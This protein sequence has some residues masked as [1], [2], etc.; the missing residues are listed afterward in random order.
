MPRGPA[1]PAAE[2]TRSGPLNDLS[3][4]EWIRFTRSWFVANP[5][6]RSAAE[7][8]HPAKFPERLADEFLR[9]FTRKGMWVLDPFAGTGSTLV[10]A[11][12]LGRH[13]IGIELVPEFARLAERRAAL[14][15]DDRTR[16]LVLVADSR[17]ITELWRD[18]ALPPVQCVLTSPPYWDVLS[19]GRG[20]VRS[21]HRRRAESGLATVYSGDS[22][23]LANLHDYDAFVTA[24]VGI[25]EQAAAVLEP[26]RYMIVVLQN[27]RDETGRIRRLAWDVAAR[28]EGERLAFQGERIWCQD[29]KPLGIWGYPSTFVPNYH[30]HYCLIF[31]RRAPGPEE[32]PA[33][34]GPSGP[35]TP[36][37]S[38]PPT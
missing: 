10:S 23:D 36:G 15:G 2:R 6:P 3:G 32:G 14:A 8:R 37:A 38:P 28:L 13:A 5:P 17:R 29:S 30:H 21:V 26:R 25:L 16:S 12:R 18:H 27:L 20:G 33:P 24:L 31:R 4:T 7:R 9:F 1:R 19:K 34:T 35:R 22:R 11:R